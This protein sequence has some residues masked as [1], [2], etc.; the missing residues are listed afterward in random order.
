MIIVFSVRENLEEKRD[1]N[2]PVNPPHSLNFGDQKLILGR[3]IAD[4]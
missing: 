4:P 1:E 2:T 3:K